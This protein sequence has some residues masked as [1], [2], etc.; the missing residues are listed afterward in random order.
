MASNFFSLMLLQGLTSTFNV[1]QEKIYLEGKTLTKYNNYLKSTEP[2]E[3]FNAAGKFMHKY[4][5]MG[6]DYEMLPSHHSIKLEMNQ[7]LQ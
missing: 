5:S 6:Q 2:L 1:C 7:V 4:G 3:Q